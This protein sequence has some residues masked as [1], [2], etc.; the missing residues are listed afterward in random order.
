MLK[1]LADIFFLCYNK[2]RDKKNQ[3]INLQKFLKKLFAIMKGGELNMAKKKAKKK[4][5]KK[6]AKKK[7]AKKKKK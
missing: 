6:V 5:T 1:T 4:A 7:A 3:Y 2:D